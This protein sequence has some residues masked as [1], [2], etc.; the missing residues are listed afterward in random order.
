MVNM[1]SVVIAGLCLAQSALWAD[2]NLYTEHR[3]RLAL[4]QP[5]TTL[6]DEMLAE[7][8]KGRRLFEQMWVIAPSLDEDI[9]GLGPLYNSISC[10]QCHPSNG[11]GHAP[12]KSEQ[13]PD[14]MLIRLS[15]LDEQGNIRTPHPIYGEQ[16]QDKA[17]PGIKPEG[18]ARIRYRYF[19]VK[20]QD[21]TDVSMREPKVNLTEPAYSDFSDV[22]TSARIGPALVGMGLI[23]AIPNEQIMANADPDDT[24]GD[25]ISGRVNWL[26]DPV[27]GERQLGRFGHKAN[28]ATL[29][30]QVANAFLGDLGITSSIHAKQNC[31]SVQIACLQAVNGGEP[32]LTDS[33]L[34][35]VTAYMQMLAIPKPLSIENDVLILGQHMFNKANCMACHHP[36]FTTKKDA[37][38]HQLSDISIS[39]YSDFLL[40]DMGECLADGRP[41]HHASGSEW[42]TAPLWGI[43]LSKVINKRATYLHDG[44]ARTLLEAILWHGGE[45][46]VSQQ[47]VINMTTEQREALLIFLKSL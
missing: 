23:D 7:F 3:G 41:D 17:I 46:A 12:N 44:R 21:G 45:A 40:H 26:I 36:S 2:E 9:D 1:K 35:A 18:Q 5:I 38:P 31:T 39:P 13:K 29:K 10:L 11:R 28:L 6:D 8:S 14:A 22:V 33:Q 42:R 20:L 30:S 27:S 15:Q 37:K 47:A 43:G 25:G 19:T 4:K 24:D 34:N 16:L 32:E